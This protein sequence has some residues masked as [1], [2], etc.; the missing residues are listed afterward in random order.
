MS[1]I[2]KIVRDDAFV[3][4]RYHTDGHLAVHEMDG[5]F[6]E[7]PL[8][9]FDDA[10]Q[11]LAPI[12]GNW[13]EAGSDYGENAAVRSVTLSYTKN[14]TRSATIG[15]RK[16]LDIV[17]GSL[18]M[19]TPCVQ[20]DEPQGSEETPRQCAKKQAEAIYKMIAEAER[21]L[22]GERQQMILPLAAAKSEPEEGE[23]LPF[24]KGKSK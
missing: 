5:T 2:L 23:Q 16:P 8:Q 13:L 10:M 24:N 9:S 17:D 21:Y 18:L 19:V 22:A 15:F 1:K 7:A 12:A 20:V 3:Q 6:H 4:I 14:G 11:K